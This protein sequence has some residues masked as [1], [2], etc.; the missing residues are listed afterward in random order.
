MTIRKPLAALASG[1]ATAVL[2]SVIPASAQTEAAK[3]PNLDNASL[4]LHQALNLSGDLATRVAV[5][6]SSAAQSLQESRLATGLDHRQFARDLSAIERDRDDQLRHALGPTEFARYRALERDRLA[7]ALAGAMRDE[8]SLSASQAERVAE[9]H[10]EALQSLA[11]IPPDEQPVD[12]QADV[13]AIE[14][15]R[16]KALAG[17]LSHDQMKSYESS[18]AALLDKARAALIAHE[19]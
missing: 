15:T 2:L 8:L 19:G 14:K 1:L 17:V 18:R 6:E 13:R 10:R 3:M 12:R 9:I 7:T 5:I 16:T 4:D 11:M